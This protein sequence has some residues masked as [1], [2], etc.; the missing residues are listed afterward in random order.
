MRDVL[1]QGNSDKPTQGS[2]ILRIGASGG[3]RRVRS[4]LCGLR[5][6][7]AAED[8]V[9]SGHAIVATHPTDD[10]STSRRSADG[11]W[12]VPEEPFNLKTAQ[13]GQV[14]PRMLE[15]QVT[16][17]DDSGTVVAI[18][19]FNHF[20]EADPRRAFRD[21]VRVAAVNFLGAIQ[22]R[23]MVVRVSDETLDADQLIDHGSL[24]RCLAEIQ[25]A[26]AVPPRRGR[27]MAARRTGVPGLRDSP[28]RGGTCGSTARRRC[29]GPF[30]ARLL[31]VGC[32]RAIANAGAGVSGRDV[33]HLLQAP[34]L[35]V[36]CLR[37][38]EAIRRRRAARGS[39]KRARSEPSTTWCE[40][41]RGR[42]TATWN[43]EG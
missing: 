1:S 12:A 6:Q 38:G 39:R 30:R 33:D 41:P 17:I 21:I 31:P 37:Q 5:G 2:R 36:P 8:H 25:E 35:G 27:W 14:V 16:L 13:F 26:E 43:R 15:E 4:A 23:K 11:Y 9:I 34:H 40:V 22:E 42:P 32:H 18:L 10:G 24:E 28:A 7:G 19:G 3:L 20:R 29:S